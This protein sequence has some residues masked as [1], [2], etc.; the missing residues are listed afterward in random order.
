MHRGEASNNNFKFFGL[1]QP[2]AD[3]GGGGGTP[4]APPAKIGKNM[5]FWHKNHDF[6]HEIPQNF[7]TSLRSVQYF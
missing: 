5:I 1:S 7:C 3:P 6:S 2:G 4:D